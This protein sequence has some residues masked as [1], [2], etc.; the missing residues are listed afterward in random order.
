MKEQVGPESFQADVTVLAREIL[1]AVESQIGEEERAKVHGTHSFSTPR[2]IVALLPS[3]RLVDQAGVI[4]NHRV[5]ELVVSHGKN[6]Q[7][8][9]RQLE[10]EIRELM[11]VK[12]EEGRNNGQ[13]ELAERRESVEGAMTLVRDRVETLVKRV[14]DMQRDGASAREIQAALTSLDTDAVSL[15][16]YIKEAMD[17]GLRKLE[18]TAE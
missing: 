5:A 11:D 8:V 12:T 17:E 1:S 3:S 13:R 18:D 6:R 16:A 9:D 2:G 15:H 7:E 10:V 14:L 4:L